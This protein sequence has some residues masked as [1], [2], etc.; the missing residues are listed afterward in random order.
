M[1]IKINNHMESLPERLSITDLLALK[2]I[3]L[4]SSV[5]VNGRQLL[6]REYD[7]YELQ[8]ND[9][10]KIVRILGGG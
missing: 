9:D 3:R 6:I 1:D 10:V 5:W 2:G 8:E 4:N 7:H